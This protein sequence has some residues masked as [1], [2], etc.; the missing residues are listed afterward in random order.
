MEVQP[1]IATTSP[2]AETARRVMVQAATVR[3]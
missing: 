1:A 2:V 3:R